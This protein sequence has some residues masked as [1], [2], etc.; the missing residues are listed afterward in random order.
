MESTDVATPVFVVEPGDVTVYFELEKALSSIE[1]I[2]VLQG[3]I[4][5][6]DGSANRLLLG[7]ESVKSPVILI[8]M[9]T[10]D[11]NRLKSLLSDFVRRVG[12]ERYGLSATDLGR[13]QS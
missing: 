3:T 1:A 2:D 4:E 13:D 12:P 9:G 11:G 7:A 10:H 8:S 5:M 6:W